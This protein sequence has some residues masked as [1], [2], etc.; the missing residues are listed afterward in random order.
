MLPQLDSG[1]FRCLSVLLHAV[2]IVPERHS[3][4]ELHLLE[5]NRT[6]FAICFVK[7]Q[8]RIV[9]R[10]RGGMFLALIN[11]PDSPA[12]WHY[13][14]MLNVRWGEG[15]FWCQDLKRLDP[16]LCLC[17]DTEQWFSFECWRSPRQMTL[18]NTP[19]DVAEDEMEIE[20]F[21]K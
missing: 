5:Q 7:S 11:K 6:T 1:L 12:N 18:I 15:W 3:G 13:T 20:L 9:C 19:L 17:K 16:Y 14:N 4:R 2:Y 10:M 8:V 21:L